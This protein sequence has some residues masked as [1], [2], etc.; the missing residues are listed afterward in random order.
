M[1]SE[2]T[3]VYVP[4]KTPDYKTW[5]ILLSILVHG[6]LLA[7]LLFFYRSPPPP[8]MQTSLVTPEQLSEIEG[9]IRAN[10]QSNAD[11]AGDAPPMMADMLS[12]INKPS[13]TNNHTAQVMNDIA[14]K[15]SQWRKEQEK[16]AQQLDAEVAQQQQQVIDQLN[17]NE[18]ASQDALAH[19]REAENSVDDIA[20]ELAQKSAEYAK[21]ALPKDKSETTK[22]SNDKAINLKVGSSNSQAGNDSP[23]R[24]GN[25]NGQDRAN[26]KNLIFKIISDN[27]Q[28]PTNSNNTLTATF[29]ISSTGAI[30]NLR[31]NGGSDASQ[32][33]LKEAFARTSLPPPPQNVYSD[34]QNNHLTFNET[35][36][37]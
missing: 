8:P 29:N 24:Q 23:S 15:E 7:C 9:Q 35:R 31:I 36:R 14:A 37:Q 34:F 28:P 33:K 2:V 32:Q 13:Q 20:K 18:A 22:Q 6:L 10:Q 30:S 12:N 4:V 26:Y 1:Y 16:V 3:S 11:Q 5:A 17:A 19:N 21:D 27:W 25:N